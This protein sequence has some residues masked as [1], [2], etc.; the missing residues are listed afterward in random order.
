M[1]HSD[2]SHFPVT[3]PDVRAGSSQDVFL[4]RKFLSI[5]DQNRVVETFLLPEGPEDS[6]QFLGV[7]R[8]R[9]PGAGIT[10]R[11]VGH[12]CAAQTRATPRCQ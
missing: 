11:S 10:A 4:H 7:L 8:V 5:N 3:S 12:V 2:L 6:Q 1:N 9:N